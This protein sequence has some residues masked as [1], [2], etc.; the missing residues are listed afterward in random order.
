MKKVKNLNTGRRYTR[1]E[2]EV[3]SGI[4]RVDQRR[5]P[6]G[7]IPSGAG[8][9]YSGAQVLGILRQ[10]GFKRQLLSDGDH[11]DYAM[12]SP[13]NN[14]YPQGEWDGYTIRVVS[15]YEVEAPPAPAESTAEYEVSAKGDWNAHDLRMMVDF[16]LDMSEIQHLIGMSMSEGNTPE[17][18]QIR[19]F[20]DALVREDGW[21][22]KRDTYVSPRLEV[23][24]EFSK[25]D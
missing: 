16:S 14:N 2:V 17:Q 4:S 10:N 18:Y 20:I 13:K 22:E 12:V 25:E 15:Q 23:M 11:C 7:A 19:N 5:S 21:V 6:S 24:V 3:M 1:A 8:G 9:T